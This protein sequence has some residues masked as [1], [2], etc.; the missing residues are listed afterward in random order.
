MKDDLLCLPPYREQASQTI[1]SFVEAMTAK[2]DRIKDA[3][4][5]GSITYD[6]LVLGR[7]KL[8]QEAAN[9]LFVSYNDPNTILEHI[10]IAT[11]RQQIQLEDFSAEAFT[12][13]H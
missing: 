11:N 1:H 2:M 7:T 4:T 5:N 10:T 6:Q 8:L 9:T 12:S 13:Q 3:Y